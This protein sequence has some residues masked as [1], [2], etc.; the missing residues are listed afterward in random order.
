MDFSKRPGDQIVRSKWL[1]I[2]KSLVE[3]L[4]DLKKTLT[5]SNGAYF[6]ARA[7]G[8]PAK[9]PPS[10][11][12]FQETDTHILIP[13]NAFED[14]EVDRDQ[15]AEL[16]LRPRFGRKW[17]HKIELR[18]DVQS[19]SSEALGKYGDKIL[20]LACGKGKTVVSLHALS[21]YAHRALPALIIVHTQVLFDQWIERIHEH[22]HVGLGG[23]GTIQGKRCDYKHPFTVAMLQSLAQKDYPKEMYKYFNTVVLDE[24]H[25]MGA[26]YFYPV[27]ALFLAERWGLSATHERADGND[28]LFKLHI[29]QVTYSDLTQ[30]LVPTTYF[31]NTG[32]DLD[33]KDYAMNMG[34]AR[35]RRSTIN[36][37]KL[38]TD[39]SEH[40]ERNELILRY[41][42]KLLSKG[43]TILALGDRVEQLKG[44]AEEIGK[45]ASP[46]VG[47][48]K[49]ADKR[50]AL[51]K[52]AVFAT[53]KLAK[54]GLDR[55]AFDTLM[56]IIPST[57]PGWLQQAYGR[58]LRQHQDKKVPKVI[59]FCDS[60]IGPMKG[61]CNKI[62]KWLKRQD[63]EWKIV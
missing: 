4:D 48:M 38:V 11:E 54:E 58:I 19:E 61:R 40:E 46:L 47:P 37:S 12:C 16:Q 57:D 44:L 24:V 34:W 41:T 13:R 7:A 45:D 49:K 63:Y 28:K 36:S 17:P 22:L 30:D 25:R 60:E 39:L 29:G 53:A 32:V 59:I 26:N 62:I 2:P 14:V 33:M 21:E 10:Y 43:R 52:R 6:A 9:G 42:R 56:L 5:I 20:S 23:V 8:R 35:R 1:R 15:V 27:S 3:D 31:V 55:S 51:T 18:D 50:A